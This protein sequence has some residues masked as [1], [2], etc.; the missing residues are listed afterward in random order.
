[1]SYWRSFNIVSLATIHHLV[2]G[3]EFVFNHA[4]SMF[5]DYQQ[6][7]PVYLSHSGRGMVGLISQGYKMRVNKDGEVYF[8]SVANI[9]SSNTNEKVS[10]DQPEE[11]KEKL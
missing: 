10:L 9:R 4:R 8:K 1:M 3:K 11:I 7:I 6:E 2:T 5:M